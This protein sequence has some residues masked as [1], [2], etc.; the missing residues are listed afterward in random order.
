[1]KFLAPLFLI[2]V[3]FGAW[4][5]RGSAEPEGDVDGVTPEFGLQLDK[6]AATEQES[7]T[8]GFPEF[9]GP[10]H[11]GTERVN[12]TGDSD[13]GEAAPEGPDHAARSSKPYDVYDNRVT[14]PE[15]GAYA[16]AHIEE[17]YPNGQ[18]RFVASQSKNAAGEWQLHGPWS[19]YYENG[20]RMELGSY[21][22]DEETGSWQWWYSDGTNQAIGRFV[23][24][25]KEGAWTYWYENGTKMSD[26][27]YVGGIGSGTWTLYHTDGS[28]K[29]HGAY[30]DGEIAGRWIIWDELGVEDPKRSG[31]YENGQRV[32][33]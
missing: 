17:F 16:G 28:R 6:E 15:P 7:S 11:L 13:H 9:L 14:R 26:A 27:F 22:D 25:K 12:S 24:G 8:D 30:H 5:W 2:C 4:I 20:Q 31:Y 1:M 21:A 3:L 33:D 29:A 18:H 10:E 23:D 32:S 19:C